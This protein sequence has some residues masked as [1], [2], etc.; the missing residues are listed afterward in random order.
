[1]RHPLFSSLILAGSMVLTIPIGVNAQVRGVAPRQPVT[2]AVKEITNNASGVWWWS[3]RVSKQLTDM[4]SN[5]LKAT[6]NFTL[7]ERQSIKQVLSE[8]ELS[9][10]GITRKSTAPKKG[11]MT[12]ARYY[13]LGS[14]SDYQQGSESKSSGG[15]VNI[16]GFGQ[17]KNTS[18]SKAYVALDIRVVDTTSGEI[19]YVRT[20]EGKATS[21][22]SSNSTSGGL[23]GISFNDS[24]SSTKKVPAS[25]AVRAAMIEVSEY[26]NCVLYL[27]NSCISEYDSKEQ[28]RRDATKDILD[29]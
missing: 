14:V 15:G 24:Q 18:E 9:D 19:A 3:P 13:V 23:Y 21:K 20:I 10:L 1:M 12:G 6:G 28:R 4:L 27:R 25:K 16:M 17:R 5:E 7:V 26:L 22:S 8:Q 11:M 29:F 2:I